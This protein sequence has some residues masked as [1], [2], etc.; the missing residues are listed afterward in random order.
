MALQDGIEAVI[1][2][3]RT[4]GRAF[5]IIVGVAALRIIHLLSQV[6]SPPKYKRVRPELLFFQSKS[7]GKYPIDV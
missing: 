4:F 5:L 7:C 1:P 2:A 6:N 3:A